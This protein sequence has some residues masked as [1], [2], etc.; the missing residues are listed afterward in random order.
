MSLAPMSQGYGATETSAACTISSPSDLQL[1]YVGPPLANSM[2]KLV[3]VPDMNYF[4]GRED[5]YEA[6]SKGAEAWKAGKA[7]F[8]GEVWVRG[9]GVSSGYWD[10]SIDGLQ[11]KRVPTNG[12][13]WFKTGDIGSWEKGKLK[14]VDRK[15]NLYKTSV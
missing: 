11:N 10:P 5:V 2:I 9:L 15:K 8:G 14:I 6:G 12:M 1:G 7:K 3:D 13:K 4:A